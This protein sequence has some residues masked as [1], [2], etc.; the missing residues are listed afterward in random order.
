M[1]V[2]QY[3]AWSGARRFQVSRTAE[4]KSDRHETWLLTEE[5]ASQL[6]AELG[7]AL[8]EAAPPCID[9][10]SELHSVDDPGCSA[11]RDCED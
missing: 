1:F 11:Q 10:G 9:C 8:A 3:R 7:K 5:E 4:F 6:H 2:H